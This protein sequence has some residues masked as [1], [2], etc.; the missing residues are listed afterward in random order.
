[1]GKLG[2]KAR[3]FAKKHLQSVLRQRRK[4]KS[5]IKR[6]ASKRDKQGLEEDQEQDAIKLTNG[7]NHVG[8]DIEDASLDSVFS[9][10]DSDAIG[11]DSDSDGY[12]SEGSSSQ[13][14]AEDENENKSHLGN[15][16]GG[17]ALLAQ[18]SDIHA[19]LVKKT[20][21]LD[22]LKE[23]DPEFLNFLESYDKDLKLMRSEETHDSAEDETGIDSGQ[24]MNHEG[25]NSNVGKLL[26][27]F[28]ID[29]WCQLVKEQHSIPALT[30]LLNAYRTA[31]H[32]GSEE[33][34]V[35]GSVLHHRIQNS[36]TFCKILIFVLQEVDNIFR[37]LLGISNSSLR[38]EM[39]LGL[40][41]MPKWVTLRPL[42]KSY[43]RS[44]LFLLNQVTDSEMLTFTI[45]RLRS[46][47]IIFGTFPSLLRRL[48][49]IA[50][51]LWETGEGSL[52]SPSF[53][54]IR[55]VA[56]VYSSDWFETCLVR[57]FKAFIGHFRYIEPT[58]YEHV[59]FLRSSFVELCSLDVQKSFSK[60]KISI[61]QLAKL[62]QKGQ[63]TKTKE[64]VKKI[65]SWQYVNCIDL[66]VMFISTNICDYDLQSLLFMIIQIINGVA[67]LFPGP[68]YLPLRLKCIQW[69]NHLSSSSG[70]FIPITSLVLDILE[71]KIGMVGGKPGKAVDLYD[72]K[73]PKHWL[74]SQNFQEECILSAVEQLAEHFAQWSYHISFPELA[75]IP[76]I[77]LRKFYD[78]TTIESFKRV[79]KRF[80]DQ[81]EQNIQFV[82][83]KRDEMVFSPKDQ[84][85]VELFLQLEKQSEN[86]PFAL[87]YKNIINKAAS[88]KVVSNQKF[89]Q[90]KQK[91]N[92]RQH[93]NGTVDA[94][95]S[96]RRPESSELN[97]SPDGERNES[98][99][100]KVKKT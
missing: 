33:T 100:K 53:F 81:V 3:K 31:C 43:L 39:I 37:H 32:N 54:I 22:R 55:D 50:V 68:R 58:S 41:N 19:E 13:Y 34:S 46:S 74:K 17:S 14:A 21:K 61:Q 63:Q 8:E 36:D 11:D 79:V 76:L 12:L 42:I 70:V 7:R 20:K 64:A 93:P 35:Y 16:Y 83:K 10:D 6:K 94:A 4:L 82:Q 2:K 92:K 90:A 57:T 59:Q 77:R 73:L 84:Q 99:R 78:I 30:S 56:S 51:H 28:S 27:S 44:T 40:K 38:K 96:G 97:L 87:Y 49:K 65:C 48:L 91:K 9:E 71:Y 15:S 18:N 66:W 47:I 86:A 24:L 62:L 5:V 25:T 80:I 85:S 69:L 1:M 67:F 45:S 26:T 75:T 88:R 98:K 60:A 89:P 72:I 23:K 52:A 29:S 95:A